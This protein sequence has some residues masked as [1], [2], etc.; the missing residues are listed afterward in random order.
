MGS[1]VPEVPKGRNSTLL[2]YSA[3]VRG[4][5][6][7]MTL[8][9]DSGASQKF[10][11]LAVL[12]KS[13]ASYESLCQDGKREEAIVR[14]ANGALVKSEG[15]QVELAFTF[16]DF[17]C[18]EKFTVLGMESPYEL[19]LGMPWLARHQ[20]WIDWRARTVAIS[21]RDT[22]KDVLLREAYVDD[23]MTV[24]QSAPGTTQIERS[25]VA[26]SALA[27]SQVT[28]IPTQVEK[29]VVVNG[30]MMRPIV[31]HR[32]ESMRQLMTIKGT[33]KRVTLGSVSVQ[34][35]GPTNELF[36]AV[37]DRIPE[38]SSAEVLQLVLASAEEI[39][40]L[41]EMTWDRFLSELKEG[42]IHE[43]VAPVPEENVVDCC[44]SSTMDE[45]VLETDKKKRFAA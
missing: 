27:E 22:G 8:L 20:P 15:V 2:V 3:R 18:K 25:G 19:I 32:A 9:V 16:S 4:Y 17:S 12:K 36:E 29:T 31:L 11:K 13:P 41:S 43:I 6:Q 28:N 42:K 14:I 45:S 26:G 1:I 39:V 37:E 5:D 10:V 21:T 7:V 40:N 44:S 30:A 38:A 24:C 33:S 23:A 35:D 34:E